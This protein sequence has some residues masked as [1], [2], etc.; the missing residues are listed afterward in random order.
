MK[1]MLSNALETTQIAAA[2]LLLGAIFASAGVTVA[3]YA[4]APFLTDEKEARLSGL[5]LPSVAIGFLAF[6]WGSGVMVV[7]DKLLSE[8]QS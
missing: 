4:T 2:W 1:R 5:I 6:G 7:R 3:L 8:K